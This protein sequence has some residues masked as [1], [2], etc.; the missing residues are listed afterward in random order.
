MIIYDDKWFA[1]RIRERKPKT[2]SE[3]KIL[4]TYQ[5]AHTP[6]KIY[7]KV[8]GTTFSTTPNVFLRGENGCPICGSR[9]AGK[10]QSINLQEVYNRIPDS[11]ILLDNFISVTKRNL[12]YCED[13][14]R[15]FYARVHDLQRNTKLCPYCMFSNRNKDND[16]F[17]WQVSTIVGNEYEILGTYIN[18]R[19]PVLI[20]HNKCGMTYKVTPHNFLRGKRCPRCKESHGERYIASLL[21]G[22]HIEYIRQ[23]SFEGCTYKHKLLF[24]FYLP[25]YNLC[26]EYDGEQHY[27]PIKHLGG[28]KKYIVGK[29][30][31]LIKDEFCRD[32]NIKLLRIPYTVS[33]ENIY[34]L[35]KSYIM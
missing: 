25:K 16:E 21:S 35:I 17:K 30:R 1:R 34:P 32:N 20:R 10:K 8:C 22:H 15:V 4:G 29:K 3:Y 7:H 23:K 2:Y 6:I 11:Y 13:C 14:G 9:R 18:A 19:T 27:H 5:D 24:D 28:K 12:F 33:L 26:I 31:D